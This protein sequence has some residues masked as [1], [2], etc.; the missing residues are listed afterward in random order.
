VQIKPSYDGHAGPPRAPATHRPRR[1]VSARRPPLPY[2]RLLRLCRGGPPTFHLVMSAS[3]GELRSWSA[4]SLLERLFG[5]PTAVGTWHEADLGRPI[6][7][8]LERCAELLG[9]DLAT[10]R[11]LAAG[12][13]L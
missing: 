8:P 4:I 5:Y 10:V 2:S 9:V 7:A 3:S 13:P 11:E 6:A 12:V 1:V